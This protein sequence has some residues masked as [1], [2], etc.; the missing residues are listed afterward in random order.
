MYAMKTTNWNMEKHITT[1]LSA[2][3]TSK[4][5]LIKMTV[6]III[7]IRQAESS[8]H[9]NLSC[10]KLISAIPKMSAI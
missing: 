1:A 5:N 6:G 8:Q 9:I 2:N 7:K 4:L 3:Q 10:S